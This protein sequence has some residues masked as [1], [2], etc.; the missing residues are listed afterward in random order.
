VTSF[1]KPEV[2]NVSY[3]DLAHLYKSMLLTC[4][5]LLLPVFLTTLIF[6]AALPVT[7]TLLT[8]LSYGMLTV[9]ITTLNRK[10][11]QNQKRYGGET[12][13][14]TNGCDATET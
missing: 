10:W 7:N 8:S 5:I 2:L 6:A 11:H 1:V 4:S 13:Y 12:H 9:D 14:V 3:H